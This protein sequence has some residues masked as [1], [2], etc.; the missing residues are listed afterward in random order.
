[1]EH[2]AAIPRPLHVPVP[3][4]G[5]LVVDALPDGI[6]Y[7][8]HRLAGINDDVRPLPPTHLEQL[9]FAWGGVKTDMK[10]G[11]AFFGVVQGPARVRRD[12]K[13][14]WLL[15]LD[16]PLYALESGL[17]ITAKDDP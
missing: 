2:A 5:Q 15:G 1:M 7:S 4:V 12:A 10:I 13:S 16:I 3:R 9:E 11:D 6:V 14:W 17:F 8:D